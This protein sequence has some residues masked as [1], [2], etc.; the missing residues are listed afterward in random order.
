MISIS[1]IH[2]GASAVV[3]R[4][5]IHASDTV[6]QSQGSHKAVLLGLANVIG[7]IS[8]STPI[9]KGGSVD[10]NC[11][12]EFFVSVQGGLRVIL[13]ILLGLGATVAVIGIIIGGLMRAFSWGNE[14]RIAVSN[15][16]IQ[17][18]IVGLI[19][20]LLAVTLGSSIPNWF[21]GG[22]SCSV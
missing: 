11:T 22:R 1:S 13:Q 5:A 16:A 18:A 2:D 21:T 3:L 4:A 14:Q 9:G 12:D 10:P 17:T 15:K 7:A 19:I 6:A 8:A 20:V